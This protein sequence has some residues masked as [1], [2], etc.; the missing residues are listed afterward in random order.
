MYEILALFVHVKLRHCLWAQPRAEAWT[1]LPKTATSSSMSAYFRPSLAFKIFGRGVQAS[2][3][4]VNRETTHHTKSISFDLSVS[5]RGFRGKKS[6]LFVFFRGFSGKDQSLRPS[7]SCMSYK[8]AALPSSHK[9]ARIAP[10]AKV[11]R[12]LALWVISMRSPSVANST[13]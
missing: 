4:R 2:A 5:F 7:T 6:F 10:L 8:P 3:L 13:V 9:A 11:I 1:P 12:L